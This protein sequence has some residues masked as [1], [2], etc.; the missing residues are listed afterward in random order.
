MSVVPH[1]ANAHIGLGSNLGDRA[2]NLLSAFRGMLDAGL[3]VVGLAGLTGAA[4]GN[5]RA[6]GV[7]EYGRGGGGDTLPGP[8]ELMA[9]LLDLEKRL[10]E[11]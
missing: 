8:E 3:E 7:S 10:G 9:L 1:I 4:G 2:G 6:A 11:A 5:V